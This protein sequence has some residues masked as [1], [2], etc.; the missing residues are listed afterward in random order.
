MAACL[1]K[2]MAANAGRMR[3]SG[4]GRQQ[5]AERSRICTVGHDRAYLGGAVRHCDRLADDRAFVRADRGLLPPR[6]TE[7][8]GGVAAAEFAGD[9]DHHPGSADANLEAPC[10]MP[11]EP[12]EE[13][14][15]RCASIMAT[16]SMA[17]PWT[18]Y[19]ASSCSRAIWLSTSAPMSVTASRPFGGW[20]RASWRSNR[21]RRWLKRCTCSTAATRM[22]RL[23]PQRLDG[24][25]ASSH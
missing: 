1:R 17:R 24:K 21:S 12:Y 20:E 2:T 10:S 23:K 22:S 4:G 16:G 14:C 11:L 13:L 25:Q 5:G 7:S 19:I 8:A 18:G 6:G 9:Q 3:R 15:G